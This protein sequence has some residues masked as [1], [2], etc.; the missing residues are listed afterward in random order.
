MYTTHRSFHLTFKVH[1]NVLTLLMALRYS[2]QYL[3]KVL[4][5]NVKVEP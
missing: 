3:L 4:E 5:F 1:N 2:N